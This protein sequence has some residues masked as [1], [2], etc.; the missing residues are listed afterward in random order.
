MILP[1]S[2]WQQDPTDYRSLSTKLHRVIPENTILVVMY[3][4]RP[5]PFWNT[6]Q[7][8]SVLVNKASGQPVDPIF[9]G[10]AVPR[11]G[12]KSCSTSVTNYQCMQHDIPEGR[13]R[14][15]QGA[16]GVKSH[17]TSYL[18]CNIPGWCPSAKFKTKTR[19]ETVITVVHITF[20]FNPRSLCTSGGSTGQAFQG[21]RQYCHIL[22]QRLRFKDFLKTVDTWM[23]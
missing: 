14:R 11:L 5:P 23:W 7:R 18:M 22:K 10:Q 4:V 8:K 6:T 1:S 12:P 20:H 9:R 16:G 19:R 21:D 13:R 17:C 15:L 3:L 2:G